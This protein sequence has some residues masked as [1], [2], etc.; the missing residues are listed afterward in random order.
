MSIEDCRADRSRHAVDCELDREWTTEAR[1][2][3]PSCNG[4]ALAL[5]REEIE[6]SDGGV[7]RLGDDDGDERGGRDGYM[8]DGRLFCCTAGTSS[9]EVTTSPEGAA[10]MRGSTCLKLLASIRGGRDGTGCEPRDG[11]TESKL[12]VLAE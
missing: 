11:R 6:G 7:P 4:L 9:A 1:L 8:A 5:S 3:D 10:R 12:G 2:D